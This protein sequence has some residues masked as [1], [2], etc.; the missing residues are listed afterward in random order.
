MILYKLRFTAP[1]HLSAR[2]GGYEQ[3]H[4]YIH[5]DT[6]FSAILSNWNRFY[7]DSIETLLLD[8]PLT[9]SSA[10]P[11]SLNNY[12]FPRPL[13]KLPIIF[14]DN[15][16]NA[17]K[18]LNKIKFIEKELFEKFLDGRSI[19]FSDIYFSPSGQFI[20][21]NKSVADMFEEREI[22]RN[23]IDRITGCTTIFYFSEIMFQE[24]SGLFFIVRFKLSDKETRKKFETILR[25]LCDVGIGGD[26]NVGKGL[27]QLQIIENFSI[28]EPQLTNSILNLSL[29]HPT[30]VEIQ[31][32]LLKSSSYEIINRRGWITS[33]PYQTLRKKSVNMFREGSIFP[34]LNKEDYGDIP[35]VAH[36]LQ[37]LIDF[38]VYRYGKGFFVHCK[39]GSSNEK[40][41]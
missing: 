35:I 41:I 19:P 15:N 38:N 8:F 25:F 34:D 3:T 31:N 7:D 2:Y 9:L 11:Y 5:S 10:F 17:F 26:R 1:L 24:D 22:S 6:L 39:N 28:K 33:P 16:H 40:T 20:S 36:R 4:H 29:F 21:L 12:Y 14:D 18:K 32:Q 30:P 27:F 13:K 37:G 23:T